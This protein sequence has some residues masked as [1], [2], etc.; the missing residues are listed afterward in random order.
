MRELVPAQQ[1]PMVIEKMLAESAR[2]KLLELT[3][4][5]P[6]SLFAGDSEYADLPLY[7]NG[8]RFVFEGRYV[9]ILSYLEVIEGFPWQLYWRSFDYQV[10]EYPNATITIEL[11]TLSTTPTFME[12]Q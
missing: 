9:E 7:Q 5:A 4:I 2:L 8:V 3:S 12:V 1:M 10:I 6:K 11:F